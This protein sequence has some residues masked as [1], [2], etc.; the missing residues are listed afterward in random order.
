MTN[1]ENVSLCFEVAGQESS[2]EFISSK[3]V[4]LYDAEGNEYTDA[5]SGIFVTGF[6]YDCE[7]I[8]AS[9]KKQLDELPFFPPLHSQNRPAKVLADDILALAGSDFE[10]VKFLSGG[11][12]AIETAIKII[13]LHFHKQGLHQKKKIITHFD[14]YHGSTYGSMSL[15]QRPDL[16]VFGPQLPGIVG[17]F[18]PDEHHQNR[19]LEYC[20]QY[21]E[22]T[23]HAEGAD[24][25]AAI[26]IE[27]ILHLAGIVT[28]PKEY[29]QHL[30][31]LCDE[32]NIV[33]VFD[34][35]VTGFGRTGDYFS[36]QG[37][38]VTPDIFCIGK[39]LSGGYSP[40]SATVVGKRVASTLKAEDS[41]VAAFA[42]SHTYA[43]NPVSAAAGIASC[44]QLREPGMLNNIREKG[45]YLRSELKGQ[46][47]ENVVLTGK[48]LLLGVKNVAEKPGLSSFG[49]QVQGELMRR[50]IIVRGESNWIAIA[51]AYIISKD[52]MDHV[53][54]NIIDVVNQ[55]AK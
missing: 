25:I 33:L 3:G 11:S 19:S 50:K 24:Q 34:E 42:P 9:I 5:I 46:L 54:K 52:E 38:G 8:K 30:R 7:E 21:I 53:V 10:T 27:P 48:G 55:Y 1:T 45:E 29:F 36:F 28:P 18:A 15:T 39:G 22:D 32:H 17:A 12:E 47:P 37:L 13:R 41:G 20:K 43:G 51:P 44:K 14:G 31:A 16:W 26:F 35:I 6:G 4:H 2:P 40:L 49:K 23:I